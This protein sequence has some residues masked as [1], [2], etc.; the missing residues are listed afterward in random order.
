MSTLRPPTPSAASRYA[1][2]AM[3]LRDVEEVVRV[4]C[5]GST[6]PWP[7]DA[8][9]SEIESN[10]NSHPIVAVS[11]DPPGEIAGFC[12]FWVVTDELS[13]QNVGVHPDHRRRGL[14][15]GLVARAISEGLARGARVALLEVRR[16]NEAAR[17][18]Y[19]GLGF[20]AVGERRDYYGRP[21]E[22][23]VLYRKP[24]S[25]A[26]ASASAS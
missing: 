1:V 13:V 9:V 20:E 2:R 25:S 8:F 17:R 22:D 4:E 7:S 10:P 23:A 11:P 14:G 12:V 24:L 21:R 26:S 16:S 19:E 5:L 6:N 15:R 3:E 18:L